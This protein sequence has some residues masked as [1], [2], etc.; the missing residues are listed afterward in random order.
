MSASGRRRVVITGS[1]DFESYTTGNIHGQQGWSKIG[2]Y[3]VEVEQTDRFGFG[4][5]R[6]GG[7]EASSVAPLMPWSGGDGH[8]DRGEQQVGVSKR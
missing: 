5:Q 7:P 8:R 6:R 3:D 1:I 2:A 4:H